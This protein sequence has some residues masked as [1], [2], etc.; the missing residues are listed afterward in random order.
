MET[1]ELLK[2]RKLENIDIVRVLL[3]KDSGNPYRKQLV[4]KSEDVVSVAKKFLAGE[5]REVFIAINLD[6]SNRINSINIVSIGSLDATIIHP[7][8]VFKTAILSNARAVIIAH[9]HPSGNPMPSDEDSR[10]TCQLF[11]CGDLLGIK[12]LD[13]IIMGD[14]QYSHCMVSEGKDK[15]KEIM[16]LTDKIKDDEGVN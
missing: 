1:K 12:V 10:I 5:D 3:V 13:H 14:G 7:R 2:K 16:W 15:K 11:Q 9:N 6:N 8:E 4:K